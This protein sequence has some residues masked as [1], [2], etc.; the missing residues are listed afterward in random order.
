VSTEAVAVVREAVSE[1]AMVNA[2]TTWAAAV[3]TTEDT[4]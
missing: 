4:K 1:A 2:T 3:V